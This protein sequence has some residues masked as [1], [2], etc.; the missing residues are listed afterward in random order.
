MSW[1]SNFFGG[2]K[3]RS[4]D[5]LRQQET[6]RQNRIAQGAADIGAKFAGYDDAFYNGIRKR[7]LDAY[8]PQIDKQYRDGQEQTAFALSRQGL[9]D[10]SVGADQAAK[11]LEAFQQ[12]R[13]QAQNRADGAT[14]AMRGNI[15]GA[16]ADALSLLASTADP[17]SAAAVANARA[18]A[19][20]QPAPYDTLGNIFGQTTGLI[21][22]NEL[23][24]NVY[25]KQGLGFSLFPPPK[26]G[27]TSP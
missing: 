5:I 14:N 20:S 27:K 23:A 9:N 24:R 13:L 10:S 11:L 26:S 8:F 22:N 17:A 7:Y 12:G 21:L 25:G 18:K 19:A 4:G 1:L 16:R 2:G 3:D 15:E 6:E